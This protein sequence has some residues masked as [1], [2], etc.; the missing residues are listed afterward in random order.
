MLTAPPPRPQSFLRGEFVPPPHFEKPL[1][2]DHPHDRD[3]RIR[4]DEIPHI[5]YVDGKA[6]GTSV[7]SLKHAY[8]SHFDA[9]MVI[10]RMMSGAN[11]SANEK[12]RRAD[13][14]MM[15]AREIKDMWD[16]NGQ[17]ASNKGTWMHWN[18][19]LC[20]NRLPFNADDVELHQYA[21]F[22]DQIMRARTWT[23]YRTE[24]EIFAEVEDVAGSIDAIMHCEADGTYAIVD[25]KRSTKLAELARRVDPQRRK[26][27]YS[28]EDVLPV[29]QRSRRRAKGPL[30]NHAD[31]TIIEYYVQLNLYRWM[32][33]R[34]YDMRIS[35]MTLVCL[36]EDETDF[37]VFDAPVLETE[38][39]AIMQERRAHV[40]QSTSAAAAAANNP[41][42]TSND[43]N[44]APTSNAAAATEPAAASNDVD[45]QRKRAR[46]DVVYES[47]RRR[48]TYSFMSHVN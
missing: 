38:C 37:I 23:P 25:W 24:W 4:F 30:S 36:H 8:F 17:L 11:W 2:V 1:A 42:A 43:A 13:G 33:Q 32:L 47:A 18:I 22:R 14:T 21:R 6:V 44:P 16:R 12:Y 45:T 35:A 46:A 15:S 3:A 10:R 5:Y 28:Y 27:V 26:K 40:S 48:V 31:E 34:Y 20:L 39:D 41:A 29:L 19:E 9:D 7:T